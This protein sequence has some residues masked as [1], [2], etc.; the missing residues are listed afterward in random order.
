MR[1]KGETQP[2]FSLD[3]LPPPKPTSEAIGKAR[4]RVLRAKSRAKYNAKTRQEIMDWLSE[5]YAAPS[6]K[7][8]TNGRV[9]DSF[10][11]QA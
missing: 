9:E 3:S 8:A 5:R 7:T 1:Y 10:Y 2:A 4:G 6:E 11:D